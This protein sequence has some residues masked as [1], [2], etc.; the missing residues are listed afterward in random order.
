METTRGSPSGL[1]S[2]LQEGNGLTLHQERLGGGIREDFFMER[3]V[4]KRLP[5]GVGVSP[6]L[7]VFEMCG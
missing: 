2:L 3:V 6:S 4:G 1:V 5:R 7:E